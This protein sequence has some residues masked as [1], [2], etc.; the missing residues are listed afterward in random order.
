MTP[1]MK[2]IFQQ[3]QKSEI[4]TK[5]S[6]SAPLNHFYKLFQDENGL[7]EVVYIM[8]QLIHCF[9]YVLILYLINTFQNC[10]I[11]S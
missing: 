10:H 4:L 1:Y 6:G 2:T 9:K 5:I 11:L 8:K 7:M 3:K